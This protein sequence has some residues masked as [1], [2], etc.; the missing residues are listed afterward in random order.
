MGEMGHIVEITAKELIC[1]VMLL[2]V[3]SCNFVLV[4][5]RFMRI[6]KYDHLIFASTWLSTDDILSMIKIH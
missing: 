2:L 5:V 6:R 4:I 3:S 1:I